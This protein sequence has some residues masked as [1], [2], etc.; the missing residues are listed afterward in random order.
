MKIKKAVCW[1]VLWRS[2][3]KLDGV[4]QHLLCRVNGT[5]VLFRT[6]RKARVWVELTH[7]YIRTRPDLRA[8][9][10]GWRMPIPVRVKVE[11]IQ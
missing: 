1:G 8:A 2:K 4:N 7:G 6:R 5:T 10:H 11:V 3:N 9:P